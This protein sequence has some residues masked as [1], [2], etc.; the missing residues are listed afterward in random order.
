MFL[1]VIS[2]ENYIY[3]GEVVLVQ[4]PGSMGSFEVLHNH[5]PLIARIDKGKLKIIDESRNKFY[6][7]VNSGV[8]EVKDNNIVVLTE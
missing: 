4:L 1:K 6:L 5:A 8:V 7:E 2:P 3:E